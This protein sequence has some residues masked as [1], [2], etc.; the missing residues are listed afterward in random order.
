MSVFLYMIEYGSFFYVVYCSI[1]P[2]ASQKSSGLGRRYNCSAGW[3]AN[4]EEVAVGP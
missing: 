1:E 3:V 2:P 4:P